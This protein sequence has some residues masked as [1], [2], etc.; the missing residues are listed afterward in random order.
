M[1]CYN[2]GRFLK[3]SVVSVLS[4]TYTNLELIV[5]DD[6]STDNTQAVLES[7]NDPRLC[8]IKIENSGV[9]TARNTG[10]DAARGDF[11]AFID[12]DDIWTKDKLKRQMDLVR[13]H[14][15]IGLV[16]TDF[17]RF[18]ESGELKN[19]LFS[20][21][22]E[23]DGLSCEPTR[24]EGVCII[25]EPAFQAL[26]VCGE[27]AAWV[28]TVLLRF[29]LVRDIR[30]PEGVKLCEDL[31]YMLRVYQRVKAACIKDTL[32]KVRRHRGNS[33]TSP[34]NMLRPKVDVLTR[35][36][37]E[38]DSEVNRIILEQRLGAAWCA[39]GYSH[40]WKRESRQSLKAYM[41]ALKYKGSTINALKHIASLP[42]LPLI[43]RHQS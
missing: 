20:Y 19:T 31:H 6:G 41:M 12:A 39:V 13:D 17:A 9:S 11:V 30:F 42:V 8:N 2:Y 1:P 35:M 18:N 38:V 27:L 15:S 14:S 16:F 7:I 5:V 3:D 32:V 37:E 28:Q 22:P 23:L 29:D 34:E 24:H 36:L 40:F 10:L 43:K 33:Y 21:L 4:Q 25:D 26:A